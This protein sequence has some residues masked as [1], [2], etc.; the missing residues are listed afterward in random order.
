MSVESVRGKNICW[1]IPF[2]VCSS[3][4][5]LINVTSSTSF[6]VL[7]WRGTK[8]KHVKKIFEFCSL[9]PKVCITYQKYLLNLVVLIVSC[10]SYKCVI[11][12]KWEC[13][14][15]K[16]T[17][18]RNVTAFLKVRYINWIGGG[19]C[20]LFLLFIPLSAVWM[21]NSEQFRARKGSRNKFA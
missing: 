9:K 14:N 21:K 10:H 16:F 3:Q 17:D 8:F 7:V 2:A 13:K 6:C 18:F 4:T 19:L 1:I 12:V 20:F 15:K 5:A 11:K